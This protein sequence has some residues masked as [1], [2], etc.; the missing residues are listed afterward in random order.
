M[1]KT[2]S[3]STISHMMAEGFQ[4]RVLMVELDPQMNMT[5]LYS[6]IDFIELFHKIRHTQKGNGHM[7]RVYYHIEA[8]GCQELESLI[9]DY[10]QVQQGIEKI[11]N[12]PISLETVGKVR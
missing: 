3:V 1:G 2:A 7:E 11:L 12:Y 4:K 5:N 9:A 6:E 8:E 10:R